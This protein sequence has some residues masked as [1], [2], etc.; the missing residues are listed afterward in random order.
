MQYSHNLMFQ[1]LLFTA[2]PGMITGQ[3]AVLTGEPSFFNVNVEID[4]V[5]AS[6][7]R[8]NFYKIMQKYPHII[9]HISHTVMM[10]VS[11]FVRQIDFALDWV[12]IE[13]GKPLYR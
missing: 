11:P 6:V 7:N 10:R 8:R 9:L 4:S 13:A 5:V 2:E 3:L 1:V 12:V